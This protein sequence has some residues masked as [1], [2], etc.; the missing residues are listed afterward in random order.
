MEST[1]WRTGTSGCSRRQLCIR[2]HD[3]QLFTNKAAL[4]AVRQI[5]DNRLTGL[6][7][8]PFN[9]VDFQRP[10]RVSGSFSATFKLTRLVKIPNV[11][12]GGIFFPFNPTGL[13]YFVDG[14]EST[15]F[16]LIAT[17]GFLPVR[18]VT[19]LLSALT[20]SGSLLTHAVDRWP[21]GKSISTAY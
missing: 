14:F 20:T 10:D 12:E 2:R 1:R 7:H 15:A 8:I 21:S 3:Q 9:L 13:E 4:R 19:S 16:S 17:A 6:G 5:I 11:D 18:P